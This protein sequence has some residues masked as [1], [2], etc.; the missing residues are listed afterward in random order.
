ME[1]RCIFCD[2]I[3]PEGIQICPQ[4]EKNPKRKLETPTHKCFMREFTLQ[5]SRIN[6]PECPFEYMVETTTPVKWYGVHFGNDVNEIFGRI[7]KD[8]INGIH[9]PH[10]HYWRLDE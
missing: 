5:A 7:I 8:I 1:D 2:E 6:T 9:N 3:I 10:V 4:C